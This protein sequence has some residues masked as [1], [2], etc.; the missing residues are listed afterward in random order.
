M[1]ITFKN[2]FLNI[3]HVLNYL[4]VIFNVFIFFETIFFICLFY[5]ESGG[6]Y[7]PFEDLIIFFSYTA[8]A[9]IVLLFYLFTNIFSIIAIHKIKRQKELRKIEKFSVYAF[10]ALSIIFYGYHIISTIIYKFTYR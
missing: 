4:A 8:I 2:L 5:A 7:K 6:Y 10:A 1:N 3:Y 9:M